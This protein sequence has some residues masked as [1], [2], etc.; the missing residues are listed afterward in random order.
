[1]SED[2]ANPR[3]DQFI[4]G[5]EQ[6]L[7]ARMGVQ[8]NYVRKWGRD[9][10]A[11]RDTTGTYVQ[12]PIVDDAGKDPTG[13]TINIL[14][15]TSDPG[16]RKFELGNSDEVFTDVHAFTANLTKR[17]T[18]WYANAGIT[19][20]RATG[21]VGGTA[22][23]TSIQQRSGLEFQPFGRNPND[24]VN[25]AGRLSGDVGWQYKLQT[26]VRLPLG[27][28]SVSDS[29]FARERASCSGQNHSGV[30]RWPIFHHPAAA[31]G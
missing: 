4:L 25:I 19:Y 23:N 7:T 17:M 1:M 3:T 24:F 11:W 20:L 27:P 13:D 18:R 31:A 6:E 29:R 9:F 8:V 14:R 5:F 21:A 15:L 22:R 30:G 2:Y 28:S 10:A 26:V 12:V 16:A